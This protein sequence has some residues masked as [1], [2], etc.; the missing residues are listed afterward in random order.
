[1]EYTVQ[2][3]SGI[4]RKLNFFEFTEYIL[5]QPIHTRYKLVAQLRGLDRAEYYELA[6]EA[7]CI[8]PDIETPNDAILH[9]RNKNPFVKAHCKKILTKKGQSV[10]DWD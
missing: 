10:W 5:N 6:N 7:S 4:E 8:T 2:E 3:D 9:S 1:M